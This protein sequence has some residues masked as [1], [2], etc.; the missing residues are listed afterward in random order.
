MWIEKI[1][2]EQSWT[3]PCPLH[4]RWPADRIRGIW[5]SLREAEIASDLITAHLQVLQISPLTVTPFTVTPR[6][7]WHFWQ[8]PNHSVLKLPSYSD[9]NS[10]RVTLSVSSSSEK[11]GMCSAQRGPISHMTWEL[12]CFDIWGAAGGPWLTENMSGIKS[13]FFLSP[14]QRH[15]KKLKTCTKYSWVLERVSRFEIF[16]LI[17]TE[18]SR[19]ERSRWSALTAGRMNTYYVLRSRRRRV[20]NVSMSLG[21]F[22]SGLRQAVEVNS[23][24]VTLGYSDTFPLSRQCHCKRGSLHYQGKQSMFRIICISGA[25]ITRISYDIRKGTVQYFSDL[26]TKS[27]GIDDLISTRARGEHA[28]RGGSKSR[29]SKL[30][31]LDH[32]SNVFAFDAHSWVALR[33][34]VRWNLIFVNKSTLVNMKHHTWERVRAMKWLACRLLSVKRISQSPRMSESVA[35]GHTWREFPVAQRKGWISMT[36]RWKPPITRDIQLR[37]KFSTGVALSRSTVKIWSRFSSAP[38]HCR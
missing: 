21:I 15:F 17:E 35:D 23:L 37:V 5:S 8:F 14:F 1:Y 6:L 19:T 26:V 9:K 30:P 10:V 3:S 34:I 27:A 29:G 7:Q 31:S 12:D 4:L 13:V 32:Q 36:R 11:E 20:S 22:C 18:N 38:R 16:P 24:R 28:L 33:A 25:S 2:F